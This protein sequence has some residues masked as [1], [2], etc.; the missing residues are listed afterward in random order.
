M[1][2]SAEAEALCGA[3]YVERAP[4]GPTAAM[5]AAR[6]WDT[7]LGTILLQNP[8]LSQGSYLPDC[9]LK[10]GRQAE[11]ALVRVVVEA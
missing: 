1:L 4:N 10:P 3:G 8:Q 6:S 7:R 5:A 9:L 2:V 11:Q